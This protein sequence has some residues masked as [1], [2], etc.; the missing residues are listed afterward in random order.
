LLTASAPLLS[1]TS[2]DPFL[3]ASA[4]LLPTLAKRG[5]ALL[6]PPPTCGLFLTKAQMVEQGHTAVVEPVRGGVE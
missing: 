2:G 6:P 4:L 1:L 3:P 5:A